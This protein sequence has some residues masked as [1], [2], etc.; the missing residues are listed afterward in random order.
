MKG[1]VE[2]GDL[3]HPGMPSPERL[4]QR[5]LAR[6]VLGDVRPIRRSSASSFGVTRSGPSAACR[7]PPGVRPPRPTGRPVALRANPAATDRRAVVGGGEAARGPTGVRR[8]VDAEGR[9]GQTDAI[10]LSIQPRPQRLARLVHREPDVDEP[11]LMVRMDGEVIT[12]YSLPFGGVSR[13]VNQPLT[14][15]WPLWCSEFVGTALLVGLGCSLVILDFGSASP[16][17]ASC[18]TPASAGRSP[19]SSSAASG[20][21]RHLA[22]GR[23]QRRAHQ[24][25]GDARLP[26]RG[27]DDRPGGPGLR[28]CSAGGRHGR[29]DSSP[30]VG[31]DRGERRLRGHRSR[32]GRALDRGVG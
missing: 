2:A 14:K 24:S 18:P 22:R 17:A 26:A 16:V 23:D 13:G 25:G 12:H 8:I 5:D 3:R 32:T 21:H 9:A 31:C 30:A 11:P 4:D 20:A 1:G 15:V 29:S 27:P 28:A 19:A 10:D 7:A 6:Q